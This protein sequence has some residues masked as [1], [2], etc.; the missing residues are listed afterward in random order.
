VDYFVVIK[1]AIK[2]CVYD[3]STQ[4]LDEIISTGEN[5]QVIRVPGHYWH[6]FKVVNSEPA[7]L[8]YFVNK[9]YDYTNPD[10]V[11]RIW[12]DQAIIP[13]KINGREDDPRCNKPWDW[14]YPPHK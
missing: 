2:I 11:R 12:N 4:E 9:L 10:E 5:I 8:V 1:G 3:D 6:G 7:F 13:K 14:L